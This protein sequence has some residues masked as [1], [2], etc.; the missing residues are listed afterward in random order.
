MAEINSVEDYEKYLEKYAERLKLARRKYDEFKLELAVLDRAINL[1]APAY[2]SEAARKD[3]ANMIKAPL[4]T[5]LD[6]DK[7]CKEFDGKFDAWART[8]KQFK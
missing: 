7:L 8:I 3:Y 1:P 2:A 5:L 6:L 4:R